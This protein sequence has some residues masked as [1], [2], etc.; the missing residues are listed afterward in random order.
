MADTPA[1]RISESLKSPATFQWQGQVGG[2]S[3]PILRTRT[4]ET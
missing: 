2:K 4:L 1:K 3:R